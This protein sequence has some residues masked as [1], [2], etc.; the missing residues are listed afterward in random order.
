VNSL[1]VNKD[2]SALKKL[3]FLNAASD[4][5][6]PKTRTLSGSIVT[7]RT[8]KAVPLIDCK[9]EIN[10]VQDLHG[11]DHPWP[12]GG[13][14]NLAKVT[15][16]TF[17]KSGV[18][19]TLANN[20]IHLN[21]TCTGNT[22]I[23]PSV[24]QL[25]TLA[26]GTYTMSVEI[27][28]VTGSG[29]L[30]AYGLNAK[31]IGYLYIPN[32]GARQ[33]KTFTIESELTAPADG[34]IYEG[35]VYNNA[36]IKFQIEK[37]STATAWTPYSNICPITGWTGA[38][39]T[40]TGKNLG[41]LSEENLSSEQ[42]CTKMYTSGG[43]TISSTGPYGRAGFVI[44]L[45][46]GEQYRVS[47]KAKKTGSA[48]AIQFNST[49]KF[50][51]DIK[52]DSLTETLTQYSFSFVAKTVFLHVG[53]YPNAT[54]SSITIEDFQLE[55][56]STATPYEPYQ[57]E[58]YDITF[59][60]EAGTVY[61][62]TLDVVNGMLTVDRTMVVIDGVNKT[63]QENGTTST[64]SNAWFSGA[65]GKAY[66]KSNFISDRFATENGG[67]PGSMIG[68]DNSIG[69]EFKLSADIQNT[70]TAL[71]QWFA[72]NPTQLCYEL[73]TPITYQLTPKE[74]TTLLGTNNVWSDAGDI[75]VT[76]SK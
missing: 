16:G 5:T 65:V 73:A 29:N 8:T 53:V 67:N 36:Q 74:I 59:P 40:R 47:Y 55:L 50:G 63:V 22:W 25:I 18:T 33:T 44:P 76:Y 23:V 4:G 24:R 45:V 48:Y 41:I 2:W 28:G 31:G 20:E 42:Y 11:Y 10:P 66:G 57:G 70:S 12:A 43:V 71:N 52:V 61:G 68:R 32:N 56:G 15:D 58:T 7:F 1:Y 75:T 19:F 46:K 62:G 39:V 69:M 26:P 72:D 30:V 38:K 37:G 49:I 17:E 34:Y 60:T 64:T 9:A 51:Y 13:G 21:G 27:T 54:G 35:N 6:M 3:L 14:K